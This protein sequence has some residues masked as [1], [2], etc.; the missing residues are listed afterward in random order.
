[1]NVLVILATISSALATFSF[2]FGY[3]SQRGPP[4]SMPMFK[5]ISR[6]GP[7][8]LQRREPAPLVFPGSLSRGKMRD[9]FRA[10][11]AGLPMRTLMLQLR[12]SPS[13][14]MGQYVKAPPEFKY[15]KPSPMPS[16]SPTIIVKPLKY[17]QHQVAPSHNSLIKQRPG[18][19]YS[20]EKPHV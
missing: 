14:G 5:P 7:P 2:P 6:A 20:Y 17:E 3:P 13:R 19:E 18:T 10:A 1:M 11:T 9:Q 8:S 12:G 16:P 4:P 15:L